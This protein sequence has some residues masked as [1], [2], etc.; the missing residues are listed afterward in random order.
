MVP[1]DVSSRP[2]GRRAPRLAAAVLVLAAPLYA[3][4][5]DDGLDVQQAL[6]INDVVTG[7]FDE[8]IVAGRNKLVPSISFRVKNKAA[9]TIR[10]VQINA[11]FRIVGDEEELSSA[12]VRGIDSEGLAGG[13]TTEPFVLRSHL[14]Y[15]GEQPRAQMLQ[16]SEFRD[17]QV[18]LF[19]KHGS[20][21][22]ASLGVFKIER[23]LLTR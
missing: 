14:G 23:Q 17:A 18:E 19:A 20:R 4:A 22:W 13:A 9:S 7:Y 16:H 5:C 8:G 10:S 15:T 2:A 6:E 21:Q 12:F 1:S 11:V 3:A